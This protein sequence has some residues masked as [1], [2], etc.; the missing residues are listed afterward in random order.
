MACLN[1]TPDV[2]SSI[3]WKRNKNKYYRSLT[4]AVQFPN[5][6]L[7]NGIE[8]VECFG[9]AFIDYVARA[10]VR[11]VVTCVSATT[12]Q[13]R[14]GANAPIETTNTF[15]ASSLSAFRYGAAFADVPVR[16]RK[17]PFCLRR[18]LRRYRRRRVSRRPHSSRSAYCL[19]PDRR[20]PDRNAPRRYSRT[21]V[22][23]PP[24][25]AD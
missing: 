10:K 11:H 22:P 5:K 23:S 7:P 12:Y 9:F 8:H 1:R 4:E 21:P 2:N 15:K 20:C 19:P 17:G 13:T 18:R 25:S 6:T 16:G 3:D 24:P 14:D